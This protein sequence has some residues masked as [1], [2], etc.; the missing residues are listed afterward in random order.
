MVVVG[1]GR[2]RMGGAWRG[3]DEEHS[4]EMGHSD[5]V[6]LTCTAWRLEQQG[7]GTGLSGGS[8]ALQS[9]VMKAGCVSD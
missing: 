6:V 9:H 2:G 5:G 1:R 4:E 3:E 8:V 7:Y